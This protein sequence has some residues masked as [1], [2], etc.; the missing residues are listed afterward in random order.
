MSNSGA[1]PHYFQPAGSGGFSSVPAVSHAVAHA[2]ARAVTIRPSLS[3]RLIQPQLAFGI[4]G[5][6]GASSSI[7]GNGEWL[8]VGIPYLPVTPLVNPNGPALGAVLVYQL[9]EQQ[10]KKCK[11]NKK[12]KSGKP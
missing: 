6:L 1:S 3:G 2:V 8:A 7:S 4:A 9:V 5:N 11:K 12:D 10:S